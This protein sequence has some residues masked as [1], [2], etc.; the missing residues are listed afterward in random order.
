MFDFHQMG[1]GLRYSD[2]RNVLGSLGARARNAFREAYG[3]VDEIEGILDAPTSILY[4]LKAAVDLPNIPGWAIPC[5]E[6]VKRGELEFLV[7][8]ALQ[9][10]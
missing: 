7:R 8:K 4:A 9:V 1:V 10:I 6:A 5:I 2:C 3:K